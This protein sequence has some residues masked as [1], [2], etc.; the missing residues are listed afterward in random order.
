MSDDTDAPVAGPPFSMAP[1]PVDDAEAE[2]G[3]EAGIA[4]YKEVF[5][6]LSKLL[7][8]GGKPVPVARAAQLLDLTKDF[9]DA[10]IAHGPGLV[11]DAAGAA[12]TNDN[13]DAA[14][15]LR[16]WRATGPRSSTSTTRS[17]PSPRRP[18]WPPS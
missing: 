7:Y 12:I 5:E 11:K 15:K 9:E 10:I 14:H 1:A 4:K 6:G 13:V 3:D 18:S 17:G 8:Y 2:V 16:W